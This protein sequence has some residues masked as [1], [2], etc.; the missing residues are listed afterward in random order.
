[1]KGYDTSD[2]HRRQQSG[3]AGHAILASI[4]GAPKRRRALLLPLAV[5]ALGILLSLWSPVPGLGLILMI[6]GLMA[7]TVGAFASRT[8]GFS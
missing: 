2:L 8:D 7:L 1:M 3:E 5:S 6:G 4:D